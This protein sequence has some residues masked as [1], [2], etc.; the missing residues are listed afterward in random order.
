M[1]ASLEAYR[2]EAGRAGRDGRPAR[3]TLLYRPGD[4]GAAAFLSS[5][6]GDDAHEERERGILEMMRTYA[7]R[8]AC[9]RRYVRNYPGEEYDP[10]EC[11]MCDNSVRATAAGERAPADAPFEQGMPVRQERFGSGTVQR[12]TSRTVTVLFEHG[13]YR[14]LALD[15]ASSGRLRPA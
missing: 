2:Q 9:R 12:L 7:E 6:G 5:A 13:V 3:C 4:L 11:V 8:D 15:L 10:R 1:P 14:R